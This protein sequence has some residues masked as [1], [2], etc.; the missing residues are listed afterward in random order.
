[1][2][3]GEDTEKLFAFRLI[4]VLCSQLNFCRLMDYGSLQLKRDCPKAASLFC[5]MHTAKAVSISI[6]RSS[7]GYRALLPRDRI[8]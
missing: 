5:F 2:S 1:L 6:I 4:Y 8:A 7:A 3:T